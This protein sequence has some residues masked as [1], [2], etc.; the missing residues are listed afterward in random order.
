M[1]NKRA[2]Q[3]HLSFCILMKDHEDKFKICTNVSH[4]IRAETCVKKVNR[5]DFDFM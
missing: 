5:V 2:W 1:K 4:T 3:R